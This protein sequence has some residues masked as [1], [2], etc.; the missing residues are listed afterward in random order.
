MLMLKPRP[1]LPSTVLR[2]E[3]PLVRFAVNDTGRGRGVR[4]NHRV[5]RCQPRSSRVPPPNGAHRHV[6]PSTRAWF[7]LPGAVMR[8]TSG[9]VPEP[10][11]RY[12]KRLRR[13]SQIVPPL[14]DG[15]SGGA[16]IACHFGVA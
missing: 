16:A 2:R 10:P 7:L 3:G 6:A 8:D 4:S 13:D 14:S 1:T 9:R 15:G 12:G 11:D 5:S